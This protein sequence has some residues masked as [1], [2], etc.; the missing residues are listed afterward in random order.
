MDEQQLLKEISKK[1]LEYGCY[2][3]SIDGISIYSLLR[4]MFRNGAY[5][6]CGIPA[7]KGKA[8]VKKSAVIGASIASAWQL[9]KLYCHHHRYPTV[10]YAFPRVEKIH[11]VYL[12]KFT[13]PLIEMTGIDNY[14]ILEHSRGGEHFKPRMHSDRIIRWDFIHIRS[15]IYTI[16]FYKR[17]GRKHKAAFDQVLCS[18]RD[19]LGV[20]FE[21]Q[22]IVK[23]F[24]KA[25]RNLKGIQSL[26]RHVQ[27][28]TLIAPARS[29]TFHIA[30]K[31]LGIKVLELQ[32]GITYGE[33]DLYSG[34]RDP[35]VI[36]DYFLAFGENKPKDVYGIDED[37]IINIGFA[38]RDFI[39]GLPKTNQVGEK[40]VLVVS[41]PE[42]TSYI[43]NAIIQLAKE[44]PGITFCFRPHPH[45][46]ITQKHGDMIKGFQ[47]I[48]IQDNHINITEAMAGFNYVV[49]EN[50]T[51]VYEALSEGKRVGRLSFEGLHIKYLDETDRNSFWEIRTT[52]DFKQFLDGDIIRTPKSIYSPF[53]KE[54]FFEVLN[55]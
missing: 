24:L 52:S 10:F 45:E 22:Q 46:V 3:A 14:I 2:K 30:A 8:R 23:A 38:M 27:A 40:D 20:E 6:K 41:D 50:S 4:R 42:I 44:F 28:T 34:Y 51:V 1:E 55:K 7:M 12:D 49:G 36:P 54:L 39:A 37:K 33:T 25:Y 18:A 5:R 11:G 19:A 43:L 9:G 29:K 31:Q 15:E 47:N 16:L 13:D 48:K 53:D 21:R 35:I 26:L 17:F 32:H